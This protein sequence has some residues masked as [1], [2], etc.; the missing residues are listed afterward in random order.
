[1]E[2]N[3]IAP[4][5]AQ[6]FNNQPAAVAREATVLPKAETVQAAPQSGQSQQKNNDNLS[7]EKRQALVQRAVA[8]FKDVYAV[9]D[10]TFSIYRSGGQYITRI[11]NLRDGRI[12]YIPEPKMMEF[13]EMRDNQSLIEIRA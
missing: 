10:S 1:M 4:L 9:S 13:L 6:N 11:T 8:S 12:T 2:L 7:D 5:P 3:N